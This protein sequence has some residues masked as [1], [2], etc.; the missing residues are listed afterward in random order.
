M[1]VSTTGIAGPGGATPGKPV[2]LVYIALADDKG[3]TRCECYVW[4]GDREAN[5]D[6]GT[7]AG[8]PM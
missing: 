5:K 1:A 3:F 4:E 7:D 2:G 8:D 6:V